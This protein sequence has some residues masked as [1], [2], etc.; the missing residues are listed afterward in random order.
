MNLY[1]RECWAVNPGRTWRDHVKAMAAICERQEHFSLEKCEFRC[2]RI[3]QE[4][5]MAPL[6][7]PLFHLCRPHQLYRLIALT[8]R[9]A[10]FTWPLL[11]YCPTCAP[12]CYL[13]AFS[14]ILSENIPQD[15]SLVPPY[16]T[17]TSLNILVLFRQFNR[18]IPEDI[19]IVSAILNNSIP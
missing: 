11:D 12:T 19:S 1:W 7:S 10:C 2:E 14:T 3:V 6:T 9:T 5:A 18:N 16:L 8:D 17:G 13:I 4:N 15:L